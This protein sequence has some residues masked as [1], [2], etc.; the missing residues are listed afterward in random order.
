MT[1]HYDRDHEAFTDSF[2]LTVQSGDPATV[3]A[4]GDVILYVKSTGLYMEEH[5]A[6]VTNLVAL[7]LLGMLPQYSAAPHS[8]T[9]TEGESY[10]NTTTHKS[11]T[12]DGSAWQPH[13]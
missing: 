11:Y 8:G 9:E 10:Y 12:W 1:R 2:R 3:P 7:P 6:A 4:T 5:S 13:W